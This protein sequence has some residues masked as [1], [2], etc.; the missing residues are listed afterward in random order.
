M[1]WPL[2]QKELDDKHGCAVDDSVD[3][4]VAFRRTTASTAYD[5]NSLWAGGSAVR[6]P[7]KNAIRRMRSGPVCG[8]VVLAV[9][10]DYGMPLATTLR[11]T[12]EANTGAWPLEFYV[13]AY[14]LPDREKAKI[15]NS[16]PRG[17]AS[18]HWVPVEL[19]HFQQFSTLR[20]VSKITFVRL[21][22]PYFL[23]DTISK[24]LYLDADVIVLHTLEPLWE[25]DLN[26]AVLGAVSDTYL[27][28]ALKR[29]GPDTEGMPQV[30]D[31]FNAGVLIIDIGL[32][33]QKCVSEVA[34]EYLSRHPESSFSDQDALNVACDT[35]WKK[36]D[37]R[38]NFQVRGGTRVSDLLPEQRPWIV[39][40]IMGSKPWNASARSYNAVFYDAFR[41]RTCFARTRGEKLMDMFRR[42]WAGLRNVLRR[43]RLLPN[44]VGMTKHSGCAR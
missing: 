44:L 22:I 1:G 23:P 41:S 19:N 14:K 15:V 9:D 12:V 31:Y 7:V 38:W 42:N 43:R 5:S 18:I 33:R 6:D 27:D 24:V 11:S 4:S 26:G 3:I 20:H 39:H 17:S 10:A 28:P 13:L 29:S 30:H 35:L 16:L 25:A 37:P 21:L 2:I 36:L 8:P 40:F 32:W 34:L